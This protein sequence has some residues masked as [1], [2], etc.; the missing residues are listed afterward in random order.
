[1]PAMRPLMFASTPSDHG[2]SCAAANVQDLQALQLPRRLEAESR[3]AFGPSASGRRPNLGAEA[4]ALAQGAG[5]STM[6]EVCL[7]L[8][9]AG[10]GGIEQPVLV[11]TQHELRHRM[12]GMLL[13]LLREEHKLLESIFPR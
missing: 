6:H 11:L 12:S 13:Q 10:T 4:D 5:L 7:Q 2:S 8:V 3:P 1:M 9:P